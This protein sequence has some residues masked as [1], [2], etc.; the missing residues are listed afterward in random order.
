MDDG[1][2]LRRRVLATLDEKSE[3]DAPDWYNPDQAYGW[4]CG[5]NEAVA[6]VIRALDDRPRPTEESR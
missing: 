4:A 6:L 5:F 1:A 2:A 3:R